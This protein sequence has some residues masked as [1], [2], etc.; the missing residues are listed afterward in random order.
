MHP[1]T[2]FG[3]CRYCGQTVLIETSDEITLEELQRRVIL[4][5]H[6]PQALRE[7]TFVRLEEQ[8]EELLGDGAEQSGFAEAKKNIH[9]LVFQ[10][11]REVNSGTF[12]GASLKLSQHD[13]VRIFKGKSGLQ[14]SRREIREK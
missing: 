5:C 14:L 6:C 10:I 11:A 2:N 7:R 8:F 4:N 1:K 9:D 12:F 13:V 3:I